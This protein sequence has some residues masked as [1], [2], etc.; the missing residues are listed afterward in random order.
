[1]LLHEQVTEQIIG[2]ALRF[3]V[4]IWVSYEPFPDHSR[5]Q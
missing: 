1:M 2:E 4:V 5:R 3:Y